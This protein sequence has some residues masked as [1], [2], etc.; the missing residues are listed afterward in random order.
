MAGDEKSLLDMIVRME[1]MEPWEDLVWIR[2]GLTGDIV[3]SSSHIGGAHGIYGGR[4]RLE[5][6]EL[7]GGEQQRSLLNQI[8]VARR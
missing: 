3:D 7:V 5:F 2:Q 6:G 8:V 1:T 4:A